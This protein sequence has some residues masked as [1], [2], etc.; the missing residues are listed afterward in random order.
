MFSKMGFSKTH[1]I[2]LFVCLLTLIVTVR[3]Y[4]DAGKVNWQLDKRASSLTYAV[5]EEHKTGGLISGLR[6]LSNSDEALLTL[7]Q[8]IQ[9]R[10]NISRLL[11]LR[12]QKLGQL[13]CEQQKTSSTGGWCAQTSVETSGEHKTDKKFVPVLAEFF[14]G[15]YV[16]SFGD[17]PGRYKQMLLDTG[18]L[19]GYDAYD[20]APFSEKT[21]EGRV[22]FLDLTL[23]QFGLPMY[24]WIMS[25]EVAEHIPKEYESIFVDNIVRHAREGIVLSWAKIGQ[26]GYSHVNTRSFEY[27]KN[28]FESLGFAHDLENSTMFQ[29][30]A[31]LEWLQWNTNVYR[32]KDLSNIDHIK[33][34]L[35]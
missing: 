21:S 19:K 9:Q 10:N 2:I 24:D 17:G 34:I 14:K 20:G 23:P 1:V 15:K 29:K 35:T 28:L 26:G 30:A 32:R 5:Y 22:Q 3:M 16:G 7:A 12:Q 33:T 11:N 4:F 27:V 6:G 18:L 31:S 25:L 13:E 8:V